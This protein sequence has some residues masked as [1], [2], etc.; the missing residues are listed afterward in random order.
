MSRFWF[1][2]LKA[3]TDAQAQALASSIAIHIIIY[4]IERKEKHDT[5]HTFPLFTKLQSVTTASGR[6]F[7]S[8]DTLATLNIMCAAII[9][10]RYSFL[11]TELNC[12][13]PSELCSV[14]LLC[15]AAYV[16][17]RQL[18]AFSITLFA[19]LFCFLFFCDDWIELEWIGVEANVFCHQFVL[20]ARA[21]GLFIVMRA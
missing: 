21:T 13:L 6:V 8:I 1:N 9:S 2:T 14:W 18:Y 19:F 4:R 17:H 10:L 16:F 7:E 12:R 11:R 15:Y 5:L 20:R 3:Q